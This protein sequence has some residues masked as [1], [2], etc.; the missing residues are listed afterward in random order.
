MSARAGEGWSRL[1]DPHVPEPAQDCVDPAH[2]GVGDRGAPYAV[3]LGGGS[4]IAV[5]DLVGLAN[6]NKHDDA[7]HAAYRTDFA[8]IAALLHGSRFGIVTAHY[9]L[10]PVSWHKD[11][12]DEVTIGS[13]PVKAL[14]ALGNLHAQ[15]MI[16]GHVHEFQVARF[17]DRPTQVIAGF[18]GTAEDPP[19][20]PGSLAQAM[21]KPG[22]EPLVGLTMVQDAFGFCL[23]ERHCNRRT[24]TAYQADGTIIGR[25]PL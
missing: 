12:T 17:T 14:G 23:I 18:S 20:S 11:V 10:Y 21:G 7:L 22:A 15:I 24:L 25:F 5:A 9:P 2:D 16:A 3:K 19:K 1:F 4:R 6:A 8:K 13:K